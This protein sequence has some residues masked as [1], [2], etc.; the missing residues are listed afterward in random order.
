M[1]RFLAV[2]VCSTLASLFY[3]YLE[4]QAVETG[5]TIRKQEESKTLLLDRARALKYNMARLSAPQV[6]ER[7]L[8]ARRIELQS[9]KSWQTLV[10]PGPGDKAAQA[11]AAGASMHRPLLTRF[12]IGTAQAEAKESSGR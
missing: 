10:L 11:A 3:V 5:Y 6:L 12:F 8:S 4:I 9:P 7:E 1:K 2:L